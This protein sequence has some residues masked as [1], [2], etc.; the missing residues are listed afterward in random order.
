MLANCFLAMASL[1]S[2][3]FGTSTSSSMPNPEQFA[4]LY[5]RLQAEFGKDSPVV[6]RIIDLGDEIER[7]AGR[8]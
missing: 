1:R 4:E 8:L 7:L 5:L 6:K 3:S 2:G